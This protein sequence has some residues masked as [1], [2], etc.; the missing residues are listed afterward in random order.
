[1]SCQLL[2][3]II[4]MKKQRILVILTFFVPIVAFSQS[5]ELWGTYTLTKKCGHDA[6]YI[7]PDKA[8]KHGGICL[9]YSKGVFEI[10]TS[11]TSNKNCTPGGTYVG[12]N[13]PDIHG[14]YCLWIK[15][16]SLM[17][18]YTTNKGC[19]KGVYAGPNRPDL[20]GGYCLFL[21]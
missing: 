7:G 2:I 17:T 16:R 4:I 6:V 3:H 12:P 8:E 11:Y 21:Q 14:G 10:H 13:R 15:G 19:G 1:M 9:H 20:H 18:N 5:P